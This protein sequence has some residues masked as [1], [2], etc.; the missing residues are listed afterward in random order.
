MR[1]W[2]GLATLVGLL[3]IAGAAAAA[4]FPVTTRSGEP[5]NGTRF[6]GGGGILFPWLNG[7]GNSTSKDQ[8]MRNRASAGGHG[9]G[10][11][12]TA[13]LERRA[14]RE[15]TGVLPDFNRMSGNMFKK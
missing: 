8:G 15:S 1:R 9:Y 2:T 6:L 10:F 7:H 4:D 3:A 11:T 13:V 14:N 5:K 12:N